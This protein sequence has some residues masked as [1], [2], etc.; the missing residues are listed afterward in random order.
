MTPDAVPPGT[1]R[2]RIVLR[3]TIVATVVVA[4]LFVHMASRWGIRWRLITFTYQANLLAA[5]FYLGTLVSPRLD[6]RASL[7]GAVVVYV[8]VAGAIWNVFLTNVSMGYTIA[9]VLLHV[10]MPLLVLVDWV[11]MRPGQ[12][13][14]RWWD[15]LVWLVYPAAYMVAAL[16]VLNHVGRRALYYFLDPAGIGGVGVA[17]NVCLLAALFLA[18]GYGLIAFG[19]RR[20]A[21]AGVA[22][23]VIR[24]DA[25]SSK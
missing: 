7:R 15:P 16:L 4:L 22:P 2:T 17:L 14:L 9:N 23:P 19:R 11:L 8:V 1:T 3:L 24:S 18:L 5:L 25:G 13:L 6:S 20:A 10:V 21:Q 12:A